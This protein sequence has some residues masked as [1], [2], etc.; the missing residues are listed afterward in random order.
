ML[1]TTAAGIKHLYFTARHTHIRTVESGRCSSSPMSFLW[2]E[3]MGGGEGGM[4]SFSTFMICRAPL[5]W[6]RGSSRFYGLSRI[7][8]SLT[9]SSDILK[10]TFESSNFLYSGSQLHLC[11]SYLYCFFARHMLEN[12][13]KKSFFWTNQF[14]KKSNKLSESFSSIDNSSQCSIKIHLN[15]F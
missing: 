3:W 10:K 8:L 4:L 5:W 11:N 6:E 12:I 14:Y 2:G 7:I 15:T 13:T 9:V 1:P